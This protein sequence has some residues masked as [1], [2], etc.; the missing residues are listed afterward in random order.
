[1]RVQ[2]PGGGAP[3]SLQV[4]VYEAMPA[5]VQGAPA[6]NTGDWLHWYAQTGRGAPGR[7]QLNSCA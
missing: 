5:L 3:Q 1:M 6:L 7:F 2:P 4:L